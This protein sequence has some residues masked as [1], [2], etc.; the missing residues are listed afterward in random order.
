[1]QYFLEQMV[2]KYLCRI[3]SILLWV[4]ILSSCLKSSQNTF[5]YS[6]DAQIYSFGLTSSKDVKRTLSSTEFTID[7]I[8][9]KIFNRDSLPYLFHVDS[10]KLNISGHT[11]YPLSQIVIHLRDADSTY[12]WN[13]KDS[14]SF[15]RLKS[16]QTTAED[17]KT[18]KVYDF[19]A[20]IHR[21]DPYILRWTK[22]TEDYF[23]IPVEEQKTVLFNNR[24]ITYCKSGGGVKSFAASASDAK[25]WVPETVSG[26]PAT[27]KVSS[28]F[29]AVDG[30]N[31]TLYVQNSDNSVYKSNDGKKWNKVKSAYPVVAL[32]GKLPSASGEFTILVAVNDGGTLKY[33]VTK[34]FVSF[35]VK[36]VLPQGFPVKQFSAVSLENPTV[37]AAKY[38]ALSGGKDNN[39][40]L[41]RKV[42]IIQEKNGEITHISWESSVDLQQG[43]LFFYDSKI[44]LMV[45]EGGKN[46]LYYS[47]NY[48]LQW[49]SGGSNQDFPASFSGREGASVITDSNNFIWIF[50]GG[51]V[52]RPQISEVWKGKLN[53]L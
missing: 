38:I 49:I 24:F 4:F 19:T 7:Q 13:G 35:A 15:K 37:F 45:Y 22:V 43:I 51:S 16:I 21:Q 50:G 23:S 48:G 3:A 6:K 17:R 26:L 8:G 52:G 11:D 12:V 41:N 5:E 44:Y 25:N 47:E 28:F 27:I 31:S 2:L 14:V 46:K 42:W 9:R 20:N 36:N 39:G 18:E 29:S 40:N 34:D 32:F 53:K 33:A 30:S 1:M 10:V